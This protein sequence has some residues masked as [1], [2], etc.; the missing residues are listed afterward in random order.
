MDIGYNIGMYTRRVTP[1]KNDGI[2]LAYLHHESWPN[3]R[4]ECERLM[5]GHF[6]SKNGD[7]GQ[8]PN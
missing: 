5:L 6:S 2:T 7:L 8:Q 1:K 4:D 3:V